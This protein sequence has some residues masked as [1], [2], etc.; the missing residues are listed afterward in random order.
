MIKRLTANGTT[1][2]ELQD[3]LNE[4]IDIL[5]KKDKESDCCGNR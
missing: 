2:E 4:L 5:N 1:N 3:K